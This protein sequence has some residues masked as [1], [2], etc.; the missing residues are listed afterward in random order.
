MKIV[1]LLP[2]ATEI[3]CSLGLADQLV[4]V[5]HECDYPAAVIG[6]PQVTR[7]IIPKD[8]SSGEI[9][10]LVR[11]HLQTENALYSLNM[12][13]LEQLQPDI[14]VTQALCDVCAVAERDVLCAAS[15]LSSKPVVINLEPMTLQDVLDT[16]LLVGKKTGR[17]VE[18]KQLL[19]D[20]TSRIS[21]VEQ[22]TA[23][24]ITDA[25]RP[26]VAFLE[27]IDP[28]FN[29]GHW[30]P[31]LIEL[32]GGI[33]CIGNK[34]QPSKTT[35]W[36]KIIA[37]QP[38]VLFIALCGFDVARTLQDIDILKGYTGWQDLPCVK[39]NRVYVTNGNFY[40]NRPGPRLVDSL[41]IIA[42]CLHPHIHA[43]PNG[44]PAAICIDC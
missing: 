21:A 34:H 23:S 44:L 16:L 42:N 3:I 12:E 31:H 37:S 5:T 25:E 40:F 11:E 20:L 10:A 36:E 18:A 6:L 30:S 35:A 26:K 19:T 1:S 2:S 41:E 7:S 27:W 17:D 4:G 14:I 38:E 13:I 33:D 39:N 43:L 15:E 29:A 8:S 24:H 9:D 28:P 22:R 32:A